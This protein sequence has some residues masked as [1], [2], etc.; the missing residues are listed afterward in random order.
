MFLL[1]IIIYFINNQRI[2]VFCHVLSNRIKEVYKK[3]STN[4]MKGHT[5]NAQS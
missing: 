3:R 5:F 1:T 2:S 4:I